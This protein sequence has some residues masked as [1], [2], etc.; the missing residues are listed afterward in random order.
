[1]VF[2]ILGYNEVMNRFFLALLVIFAIVLVWTG[3]QQGSTKYTDNLL[4][5]IR[6][7]GY[8]IIG[9]KYDSPPF[10]FLD[11]DSSLKGLEIELAH[12]LADRI[13]GDPKA[14]KFV[15]VNTSTR[16]AALN[17]RQ[18]DFV[19]A[20]MTITPERAKVVNFTSPYYEAAQGVMVKE[21]SNIRGIEELEGRRVIYV[22]GSTGEANLR[23]VLKNADLLGFK[24]STEA[25]TAFN[26]GRADAFSTDDSILYG[27]LHEYCGLRLLN[28]RISTEPYGVAFRREP[29]SQ[30]LQDKVQEILGILQTEGKLEQ[31]SVKWNNPTPPSKCSKG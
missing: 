14:V 25:F 2:S 6:Q 12:E 23:R 26:S 29:A 28:E 17:A 13:L 31:L 10:G 20:T 11:A 24:S 7:R 9:V 18:L 5:D 30:P 21:D 3:C 1:M 27:F 8:L 4:D 19:L 15:Q 16:V 22:I